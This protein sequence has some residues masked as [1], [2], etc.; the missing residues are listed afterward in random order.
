MIASAMIETE[1]QTPK[2]NDVTDLWIVFAGMT[3]L[4]VRSLT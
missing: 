2:A 1:I 3:A 4:I